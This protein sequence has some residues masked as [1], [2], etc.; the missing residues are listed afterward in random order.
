MPL[1]NPKPGENKNDYVARCI[2]F[3]KK[4]SPEK[5]HEQVV[6]MCEQNFSKFRSVR[7]QAT[8]KAL[9]NAMVL[10]G[11]LLKPG[12]WVGLDGVPTQYSEDFI[13]KVRQT[14]IGKPIYFAH[15]ISPE[16]MD[17]AIPKGTTVGFFTDSKDG[18]QLNVR[19]Y[20]FNPRAIRYLKEHPNIGL[21]M[22]AQV[23][24]WNAGGF[25]VAEDGTLTGG[26]LIEDPACST[27][28][29]TSAREINLERGKNGEKSMSEQET[30]EEFIE[31]KADA[32]PGKEEFFSWVEKQMKAAGIS[33]AIIPKAIAVLKKAIKIPYPYPYPKAQELFS[34]IAENDEELAKELASY[35]EY[36]KA[37]LK[38]GKSMKECAASYKPGY[39]KAAEEELDKELA[40]YREY[41]KACMKTGKTMK[42]CA[43]AYKP[44][45]PGPYPKAGEGLEELKAELDA[46]K[47]ALEQ[48]EQED[49]NTIVSGIREFDKDFTPEKFLEGISGKTM[50]RKV[51]Q[52]YLETLKKHARPI[53]LQIGEDAAK[54]T[55]NKA[56]EEMF[57]K[58]ATLESILE[59]KES[60]K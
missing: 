23:T 52:K 39:P 55:V 1:P 56:V 24:G 3:E 21:S 59:L 31:F 14:I 30:T 22:E 58:G 9:G 7:M 38:T 48:R 46:T 13:K 15:D 43:A 29:V 4:E 6:A 35:R 16:S 18:G 53:K 27:C 40:S 25:E 5:P 57:G 19:G 26:A 17:W 10:T 2:L 44:D 45:Y 12:V 37:C 34:I 42:E 28:R 50:Q 20:I 51:L 54:V 32:K 49:I 47:A 33:D 11:T 60:G 41:M 8:A 36:M